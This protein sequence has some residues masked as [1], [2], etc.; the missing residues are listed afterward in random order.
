MEHF[1][2]I[3]KYSIPALIV[4]VTVYYL[5]KNFLT[6]QY[7]IEDMRYQQSLGRDNHNLKVQSLERL[8]MFVER[9]HPDNLFYRLIDQNIGA[10]EL[11][12]MMLIAIQQEYEHNATQQLYVSENLW[13]IIQLAKEQ[14]QSLI[15][16]ATGETSID[17]LND[18]HRLMA[19][20]GANPT[21]LAARAIK[22][23]ATQIIR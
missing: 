7:Q 2:E 10:N 5:F 13:K 4:F 6:H 12:S 11:R 1:L 16:N 3:V 20:N 22:N 19:E 18:I 21:E 17:F 15:S 23:E 9:M 8:T 14:V